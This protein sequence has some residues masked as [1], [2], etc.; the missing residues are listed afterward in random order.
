V[1]L[2]KEARKQ[3]AKIPVVPELIAGRV[4]PGF[5]EPDFGP[6]KI[7]VRCRHRVLFL[8]LKK[9]P[10]GLPQRATDLIAEVWPT[11]G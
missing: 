1:Q 3:L 9:L 4:H 5:G 10:R 7:A 8:G 2:D 11:V 6:E